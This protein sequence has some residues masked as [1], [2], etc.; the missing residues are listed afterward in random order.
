MLEKIE[1]RRLA[2]AAWKDFLREPDRIE[3]LGALL[4][5]ELVSARGR[6][7]IYLALPDEFDLLPWL[8]ELPESVELFAPVTF[9]DR[10][11]FRRFLLK[12][13]RAVPGYRN[14]PGPS[15]RAE[16]L[17]W[18]LQPE[19]VA[20]IPCLGVNDRGFRLG[21]GGGYYDRMRAELMPARRI[22]LLPRE[23]SVMSFAEEAHDLQLNDILTDG[24]I[25]RR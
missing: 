19:D 20:V 2:R 10:M 25:V 1:A 11:E 13:D 3:R 4:R 24:G 7:L 23:L 12:S 16:A 14:V 5:A 17:A 8:R 22:A 21:R 9:A 6:L 18:P 15:P